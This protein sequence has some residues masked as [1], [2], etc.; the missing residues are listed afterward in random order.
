MTHELGQFL[1]DVCKYR[2][3]NLKLQELP[4]YYFYQRYSYTL[5]VY[6]RFI[7]VR[8]CTRALFR[9]PG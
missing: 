1:S 9:F 7:T 2:K 5:I 4:H 6:P 3:L 8:S